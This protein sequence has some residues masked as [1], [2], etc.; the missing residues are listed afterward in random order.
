MAEVLADPL[1]V[2]FSR[3][4]EEGEVPGVWRNANVCPI[5]KKGTKGDPANCR[6]VSLTC[7]LCGG[8]GHGKL[9]QE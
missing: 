4:M 9:D 5:F 6:L 8:E 3:L 7:V 2:I 1:S